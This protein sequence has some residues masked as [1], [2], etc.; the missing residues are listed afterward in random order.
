MTHIQKKV[1]KEKHFT[2]YNTYYFYFFLDILSH[3]F[4][5]FRARLVQVRG[6]YASEKTV[7]LLADVQVIS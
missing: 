4:T 3:P 5:S 2:H 6:K 1:K 7:Q